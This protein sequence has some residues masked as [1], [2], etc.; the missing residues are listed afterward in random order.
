MSILKKLLGVK[1]KMQPTSTPAEKGVPS[2]PEKDPNMIRVHDAYGRELF[3]TKQA[4]HDSVLVG[5]IKKV[6]DDPESLYSTIAQALQDGFGTEMVKPAEHLASIDQNFERSAV[7][8]AVVYREQKRFDDS[9]RALRRHIERHGES[10]IILTNLAK[11]QSSR[12]QKSEALQTLWRG[13]QLDPN[14]SNGLAWYEAIHREQDGPGGGLDAL[15]RIAALPGGWRPRLWLAR[16]ALTRR[17]LPAALILYEEAFDLAPRPLPAD[18]LQQVSGD[19]GNQAHLLE[20]LSFVEPHFDPIAHGIAVG[21]NL[22]KAHLDLGQLDAA[23]ALVDRLY[24][25]KRPDW[26]KHLA[27][28]DTEIAKARAAASGVGMPA[29]PKMTTVVIDGPLWLREKMAKGLLRDAK[30]ADAVIVACLGSSVSRDDIS[31]GSNRT[32]LSDIPGRV[33][34]ALPTFLA[35]QLHLRTSAVG[36]VLQPWV[37]EGAG[38]FVLCGAAWSDEQAATLARG[39]EQPADYV[40]VLH[41]DARPAPWTAALR[42]IRTID[43]ALLDVTTTILSPDDPQAGFEAL[44]AELMRLSTAHAQVSASAMPDFYQVPSGTDFANYQLRLEQALAVSMAATPGIASG[45]LSGE[46]EILAGNLG[47]CLNLPRNP[48]PRLLLAQT[49]AHLKK[50]RPDVVAEFHDKIEMLQREKPLTEPVQR[51]VQGILSEVFAA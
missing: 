24:S 40:A 33:S 1:A 4:W 29:V 7:L 49:L 15:R 48:T 42:L 18:L 22:I 25:L 45:F 2:D 46:R 41:I 5:H 50:V 27:F 20:I 47:L 9:E 38:G 12:G 14:Q 36:R 39:G 23:R 8:L 43:R 13:L 11:V 30:Q 28:W 21:N 34:R 19:L 16:D 10:G 51:L 44:A 6:W 32:Q 37:Q 17:D 26:Q 3:I 35:E 31:T